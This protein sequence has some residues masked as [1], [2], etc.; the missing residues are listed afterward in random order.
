MK[1]IAILIDWENI[2]KQVFEVASDPNGLNKSVSYNNP[3]NVLKFAK[4]FIEPDEEIYRI[5]IY[6]SRPL[7]KT[8]WGGQEVDFSNEPAYKFG[9]RFIE[10][11][12]KR[13]LVA[14]RKGKLQY[15]G[16]KPNGKHDLIQKQVD[17]LM[18]LDISHLA[19][20]HLVDRMLILS[21]DTD[22][23]PALK[24]ARTHGIQMCVG[25]CKDIQNLNDEVKSH[26]DFIREKMFTSIFP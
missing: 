23:V 13:D 2:R 15:R 9:V 5:Y 25:Y 17:M 19:F 7:E 24:I 21:Y 3:D 4:A 11:I 20:Y 1:R 12:S 16:P 18:G 8:M 22:F 10:N 6:L 14:I 26:S